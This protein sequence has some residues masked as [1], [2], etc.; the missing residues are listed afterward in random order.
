MRK[1]PYDETLRYPVHSAL[2]ALAA[3]TDEYIDPFAADLG[4]IFGAQ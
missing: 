1:L 2:L 4:H 3:W